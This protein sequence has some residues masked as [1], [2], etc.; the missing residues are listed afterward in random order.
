MHRNLVHLN[1]VRF[2]HCFEDSENVY[3]ILENCSK[4]VLHA[5]KF[6]TT[7]LKKKEERNSNYF[8]KTEFS[9]RDETS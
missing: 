4:K 2:Y 8:Y 1:V 7:A 9:A 5:K 3:I 6:F